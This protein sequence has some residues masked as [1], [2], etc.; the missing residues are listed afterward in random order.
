MNGDA[1]PSGDRY[2]VDPAGHRGYDIGILDRYFELPR[3]RDDDDPRGPR[4]L[5]RIR[6]EEPGR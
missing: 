3:D 6:P 2:R 4:P 5:D 1:T